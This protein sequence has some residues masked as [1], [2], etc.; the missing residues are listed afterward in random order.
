MIWF[1][2]VF[3]WILLAVITPNTAVIAQGFQVGWFAIALAFYWLEVVPQSKLVKERFNNQYPHK[4]W[5]KPVGVSVGCI[6]VLVL[7]VI[8]KAVSDD[9][10]TPSVPSVSGGGTIT[11]AEHVD[12]GT[13]KTANEGTCFSAGWVHFLVR[14]KE[15]FGDTKLIAYV[16]IHGTEAWHT[17]D[18]WT[19]DPMWD[20]FAKPI[21]LDAVGTYDIKVINGKGNTIATGTVQVLSPGNAP[22]VSQASDSPPSHPSATL[23]DYER[24]RVGMTQAQ[25]RSILG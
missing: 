5:G 15:A 25:V 4:T 8:A 6:S 7:L 23:A 11:F 3:A 16:R 1:Y 18:E 21:L 22:G 12:P 24:V 14:A 13:L 2:S 10:R 17:V 20:V 9:S 19:V